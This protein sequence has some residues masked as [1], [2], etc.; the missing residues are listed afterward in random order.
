MLEFKMLFILITNVKYK[1]EPT[2]LIFF[3]ASKSFVH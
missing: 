1:M 2:L 3:F